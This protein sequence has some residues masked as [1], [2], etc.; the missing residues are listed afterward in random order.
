MF[1]AGC[2]LD[3]NFFALSSNFASDDFQFCAENRRRY[4]NP[5]ESAFW[6][7]SLLGAASL[8]FGM[9]AAFLATGQA[10]LWDDRLWKRYLLGV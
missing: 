8:P 2:V 10:G 3:T 6:K 4:V 7:N 1:Y 9:A 5:R